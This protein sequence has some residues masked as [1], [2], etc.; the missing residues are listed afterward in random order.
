M[1][2]P[3][4]GSFF[5]GVGTQD[6][7]PTAAMLASGQL[8]LGGFAGRTD[9]C[10][11]VD[12][13]LSVRALAM[14][15]D[16]NG[17][18]VLVSVD[19]TSFD[20][21]FTQAVT[22][23]PAVGSL[24]LSATNLAIAAIHTHS[25]PVTK[26]WPTWPDELQQ[27]HE[28]YMALLESQTVAAIE[29]AIGSLTPATAF[30]GRGT[31]SIGV[32]RRTT[33]RVIDDTVDVLTFVDA[34]DARIATLFVASCHPVVNCLNAATPDFPAQ[35]RTVVEEQL[36]GTALFFQGFGGTINPT[37]LEGSPADADGIGQ[38]L[39]NDVV[40]IVNA[41][42]SPVS[43]AVTARRISLTVSEEDGPTFDELADALNYNYPADPL[44]GGA[45]QR[46]ANA[47]GDE[48][49][50]KT[51]LPT[52]LQSFRI[53]TGEQGWH[54]AI[55]SH[56]LANEFAPELRQLWRSSRLTLF[57]YSGSVDC[58][59]CTQDITAR[60]QRIPFSIPTDY[61]A[62]QAVVWYG[63]QQSLSVNSQEDFMNAAA[64][65]DPEPVGVTNNPAVLVL[66]DG[67]LT[68]FARSPNGSVLQS[69]QTTPAGPW[70]PWS[71]I[72]GSI[73]GSPVA[74]YKNVPGGYVLTVFA[75]GVDG[76]VQ[77]A[78]QPTPGATWGAWES[79][80]ASITGTPCVVKIGDDE[81]DTRFAV[82]ARST[83]GQAI[84]TAQASDGDAFDTTWPSDSLAGFTITD[85]PAALVLSDDTLAV[86][87]RGLDSGA[88]WTSQSTPVTTEGFVAPEAFG[89][90]ILGSPVPAFDDGASLSV[91]ATESASTVCQMAGGTATTIQSGQ[92]TGLP[93]VLLLPSGT[94]AVF[95]RGGDGLI[96]QTAQLAPGGDW[97]TWTTCGDGCPGVTGSPVALLVDDLVQVFARTVDGDIAGCA[98]AS[99]DGPFGTWTTIGPPV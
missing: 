89:G 51:E 20:R 60:P 73:T 1:E 47:Y 78:W 43:G 41:G 71:S 14:R 61:E 57:A 34:N 32:S 69:I 55:F 88:W 74:H 21:S 70:G 5:A 29:Q 38:T 15:D 40:D 49:K 3:L 82:V 83:S 33:G 97:D 87:G 18:A 46:W 7:T 35:A 37:I 4:V 27:P 9:P 66:P 62:S 44:T 54:G 80:G 48:T 23:T 75:R 26:Y 90:S 17:L 25:A 13:P 28:P 58:Y 65:L 96:W 22:A 8:Y 2:T 81:G 53:G 77:Q 95:G 92:I 59:L 72:G 24:G 84:Q 94:F 11:E 67:R 98:Q 91:F 68:A 30:F 12:T 31:T 19:A 50:L 56:E 79:I 63:L 39:G 45:V 76:D 16:A 93:A 10:T 64:T 85:S 42:V 6:I 86:F 52:D 99:A 36:G